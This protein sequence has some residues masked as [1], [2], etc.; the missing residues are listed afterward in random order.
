VTFELRFKSL[1]AALCG[2]SRASTRASTLGVV[3][4]RENET[5]ATRARRESRRGRATATRELRD[6]VSETRDVRG[7][8][9]GAEALT[10]DAT[11]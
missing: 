10:R 8:A 4:E 1:Y 5:C 6:D 9:V 3:V 11:A 2:A 7:F